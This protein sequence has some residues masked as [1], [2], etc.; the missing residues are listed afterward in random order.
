[1]SLQAR[2]G[3][4]AAMSAAAAAATVWP[5]HAAPAAPSRLAGILSTPAAV[6]VGRAWLADETETDALRI[7]TLL[8]RRLGLRPDRLHA[9][10]DQEIRERFRAATRDD[11]AAGRVAI[12]S[13]WVLSDTEARYC[14]L[15]AL[16]QENS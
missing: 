3:R 2:I 6:S 9:V 11:F 13:S 5:S 7:T 14:G 10:G 12:V 4:R 16:M 1:M 8:L 15:I